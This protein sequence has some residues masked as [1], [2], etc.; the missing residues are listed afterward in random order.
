MRLAWV[1]PLP[2]MLSGIADYSSEL[3]P[4]VAERAEV[5]AVCPSPR[6]LKRP[7]APEGIRVFSPAEF[8][9]RQGTYDA[10][11]HHL[12]NN[13]YHRFVYEL[14]MEVPSIAVFHDLVLHHLLA[15]MLVEGKT[16]PSRY[17]DLAARELGSLGVKLAN[18]RLR[19]VATDYEKFL[20]PLN[21][22][23]AGRA[24]AIVV[25][26]GD[27]R[28]EIREIAPDVPIT[29]IPHHAERPPPSVFGVTR[30]KA[31]RRL[32]LPSDSF[33]VGHFGFITRPKQP[34]AVVGGFARLVATNPDAVLVMAGA[35]LTGGG[36]ER[37]IRRHGLDGR[38]KVVGYV[39]LEHFYLYLLAADAV[40]NLRFPSAGE[41]SGTFARA[42]AVGRVVVVNNYAS[43]AEVPDGVA[44]KVEIDGVQAEEIGAH[45][46]RLAEDRD[47]QLQVE[48]NA[49][50]YASTWLDPRGCRDRYLDVARELVERVNS[51]RASATPDSQV[52]SRPR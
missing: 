8:R 39:D 50:R 9:R 51:T 42:L 17:R 13:P 44:L 5:D 45:L 33:V 14:A 12:A 32:G 25:H 49:R 18:L 28:N 1:S 2:P 19:G 47:L 38:V 40:I 4:L 3:L 48:D 52:R 46:I 26:S 36:L 34:A 15:H 20:F 6:L 29:V 37:L 24:L 30:E 11:I 41:S 10:V 16:Q 22:D 35:D 21:A 27:T 7:K 23:M 43:F 31:R